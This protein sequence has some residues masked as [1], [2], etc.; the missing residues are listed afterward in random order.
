MEKRTLD[1]TVEALRKLCATHGGYRAVA[2]KAGLNGWQSIYQIAEGKSPLLSGKPRGVGPKLRQQLT[3]A[4]PNWLSMGADS[5]GG[6]EPSDDDFALV[7]QLNVEAACGDGRFVDHVVVKGGLAFKRSSLR[8]FG[9]TEKTA[10]V[11]YARGHSMAPTIQDGCVVLI[12][13]AE[14]EPRDGKVYAVCDADG[15]MVLKRLVRDFVAALNGVGWIMRSDN[16]NKTEYPDKILPPDE[17]TVIVGRAVWN[18][19]R[20]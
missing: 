16:P 2:A 7:A 10:R 1:P 14:T 9:L 20:L 8:D 5:A 18:D 15:H 11:I 4:F 19:N 12:N 3:Q 13:C 17:R 6:V